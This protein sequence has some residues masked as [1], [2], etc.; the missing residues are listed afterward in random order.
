[1]AGSAAVLSPPTQSSSTCQPVG[2]WRAVVVRRVARA[3]AARAR[4]RARGHG[5]AGAPIGTADPGSPRSRPAVTVL[6]VARP[7]RLPPGDSMTADG[8]SELRRLG[9]AAILATWVVTLADDALGE[10]VSAPGSIAMVCVLACVPR[11]RSGV[12][13]PAPSGPA[14]ACRGDRLGQDRPPD[15]GSRVSPSGAPIPGRRRPRRRPRQE[16]RKRSTAGRARVTAPRP[17]VTRRGRP[18]GRGPRDRR[19]CRRPSRSAQVRSVRGPGRRAAAL[20][21]AHRPRGAGATASA[22]P[23]C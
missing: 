19:R 3:G 9:L 11:R 16:L 22:P 13:A 5:H 18:R 8:M 21:R 15:H 14:R 12:A 23:R 20:L 17:A 1:M 10:N 7:R 2:G 4:R 6:L